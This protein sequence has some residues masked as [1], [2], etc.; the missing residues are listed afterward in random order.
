MEANVTYERI[1]PFLLAVVL[2]FILP[3]L[4]RRYGLRWEDLLGMLT[5]RFRKKDY[6]AEARRLREKQKDRREPY[7][8]NSRSGD[9]KSLVSS[10]LI[11]ARRHKLGLVYPGTVA[12]QGKVAGLLALVVTRR[13][14]IG[15]NCFGYG[16]TITEGKN[17]GSWNQHMNGADLAFESPLSGNEK[18]RK[19]VRA[20]MDAHGMKEVPLEVV[21]VFT[22]RGV[23]VN[24][25]RRQEVFDTEGLIAYLKEM[26]VQE[27]DLDPSATALKLNE[28]VQRIKKK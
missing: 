21:S 26:A 13:K 22:S 3:M 2:I 17:N 18:Q 11:L 28:Q 8:T 5:S 16:G 20:S 27:G 23:T 14:V 24:S 9:L 1:L 4:M 15:L 19:L 25:S 6:D 10:L 7:L 12:W